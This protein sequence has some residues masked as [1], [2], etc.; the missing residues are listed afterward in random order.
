MF[1]S[2]IRLL[3]NLS[4]KTIN[5]VS[6]LTKSFKGV[7]NAFAIGYT[8]SKINRHAKAR[9]KAEHSIALA[10]TKS[11]LDAQQAEIDFV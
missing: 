5:L 6:P 7:P 8:Q 4:E 1:N 9:L 11:R 10:Q 2:S 3:G